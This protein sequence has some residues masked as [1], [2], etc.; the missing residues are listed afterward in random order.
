MMTL[1]HQDY[2]TTHF[3]KGYQAQATNPTYA[4]KVK[5]IIALG[6]KNGKVLDVGCAYG[7]LLK[8]FEKQ[9]FKTYGIDISGFALEKAKKN[10]QAKLF[11]LDISSEKIPLATRSVDIVSQMFLLE[12][13]ENYQHCLKESQRVLKKNGLLFILVPTIRRWFADKTHLNI[14][15]SESLKAVLEKTGF[16]TLKIGEEGGLFMYPLGLLRLIL[17]G[18]TFFNFVPIKTGSFICCYAKKK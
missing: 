6:F 7:F 5:E 9:G 14:F 1:Y 16:E 4:K 10:C 3:K 13:L 2:F 8:E 11:K 15:T 18:N 17:K 12:H